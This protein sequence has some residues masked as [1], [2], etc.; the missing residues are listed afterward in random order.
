[1][2]R[3]IKFRGFQER[4]IYGGISI[5]Q[6]EATIFDV[7]CFLNSAYE[8]DINSVAQ[9]TGVKDKNGVEIYEGDI[10]EKNFE[11]YEILHN[12]CE[13]VF[14]KL[15]DNQNQYYKLNFFDNK[16]F[17]VTGNIYENPELLTK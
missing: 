14:R 13:W 4:W 11:K 9:Y 16:N 2:N 5:F 1:M 10:V 12:N 7:N 8:V 15:K 17:E 6:N 3:E